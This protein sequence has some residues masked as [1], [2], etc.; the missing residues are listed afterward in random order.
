MASPADEVATPVRAA[1]GPVQPKVVGNH[2]IDA[3]NGHVW[4]PHG[5]N[6]PDLEYAC[7][8]GWVPDHPADEAQRMASWGIDVVRLPLNQDCWLGTDGANAGGFGTAGAYRAAVRARVDAAH[9]AGLVAILDLHWTGPSGTRADGQRSMA[10]AQSATFWSQVATAY[11][12][13]PSVMFELFNEPF[14]RPP[15]PLTWTCWR[16]GGCSLS[17]AN[18]TTDPA[19]QGTYTAVGMGTLVANVRAAGSTQPVLLGGLNYSNDLTQWLAF[20]PDDGQLVAAWH[21]YPGQGCWVS[22]WNTTIAGV[23]AQ[24]PVLM[25][26]FGYVA[27]DAGEFASTMTWADDHGIGYLPWA[28]WRT[29]ASDGAAAQLYALVDDDFAPKAPGGVL[30]H[31][32]LA[33]LRAT[34]GGTGGDTGAGTS[35]PPIGAATPGAAAVRMGVVSS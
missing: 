22:C 11:R 29:D 35:L 8:Q 17:T 7:V 13:D 30:Y 23:A 26:E 6:W 34:G 2:L 5:A 24:V 16:D 20:R 19:G 10:D 25:T 4:V 28:W 18:D 31:D 21:N 27:G 1:T 14:S 3:R 32:H 15:N 33:A 12:D 9:D